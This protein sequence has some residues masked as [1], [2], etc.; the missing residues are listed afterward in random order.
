MP[1]VIVSA[2]PAG[3]PTIVL[4]PEESHYVRTVLRM[5][6]GQA[7]EI[8]DAEGHRAEAVISSMDKTTATVQVRAILPD[9]IESKCGIILLQG[10]LKGQK[11]DLVVQKA[12]E[13]GA[14]R[15]VPL[16]TQRTIVHDTRKNSRWEKIAQEAARQCG[17]TTVPEIFP[18]SDFKTYLGNAG[19]CPGIV[20]WEDAGGSTL[21]GPQDMPDKETDVFVLVGPEG[22]LTQEEVRQANGAGMV[23]RSLGRN[24]LRAET[25]AIAAVTLLQYLRHAPSH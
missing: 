5:K 22:G 15:I 8:F 16:V 18:A 3:E 10:I 4:A 17:R 7:L 12:T 2:I 9:R 21:P 23:T 1:R 20:F 14:K 19:A 13:L 11:M 6:P 24:I 25:A